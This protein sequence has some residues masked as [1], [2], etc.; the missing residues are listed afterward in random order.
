MLF[1]TNESVAKCNEFF[2]KVLAQILNIGEMHCININGAASKSNGKS[3][4]RSVV[5][6]LIASTG[7]LSI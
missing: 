2:N 5:A 6:D 7:H 4:I 3:N 1:V